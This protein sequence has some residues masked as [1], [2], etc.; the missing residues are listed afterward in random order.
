M[1]PADADTDAP[2]F[3]PY[4]LL[5]VLGQ[6]SMGVVHL[7]VDDATGQAVA[8]KL[9]DLAAGNGTA[10]QA[11][12]R[13]RFL[14]EAEPMRRLRHPDIVALH[15]AGEQGGRGWLAM[16]LITGTPLER[17][18]RPARL[19]PEAVVLDL[20]ARI[21]SALH[22]AHGAGVVHR[23]VKPAN[24]M[25]DWARGTLKLADFGLARLADAERTRTGLVLGSPAYMAP[26]QLAGETATPASDLY[27]LGVVLF[28]LLAGRLP[29]DDTSLGELLRQ[30]AGVPAPDLRTV[31]PDLP[32][33]LAL[34]VGALLAKRPAERPADAE[35]AAARLQALREHL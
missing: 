22:H 7:A 25:V 20:G 11:E 26:E 28:Q 19:L 1:S 34:L 8:L 23:D 9:I 10:A 2:R 21:A 31:R 18:T 3:G 17:Y 24:V 15:A 13:A 35:A 12:A 29:H 16:E 5:R 30:V 27:A 6:G 4:R 14:A 32:A 33:P